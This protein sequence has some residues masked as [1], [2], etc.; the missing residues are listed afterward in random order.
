MVE[1]RQKGLIT[2]TTADHDCLQV[3]LAVCTSCHHAMI[4]DCSLEKIPHVSSLKDEQ[5]EAVAHLLCSKDVVGIL[6][7]GFGK[8]LIH[9][10]YATAKQMQI[11]GNVVVLVVFTLGISIMNDQ[12]EEMEEFEIPLNILSI[13]YDVLQSIGD[14]KYKLVFGAAENVSNAEV[15]DILKHEDCALYN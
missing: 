6:P 11:V 1:R 5:K 4:R 13:T 3:H 8:S 12:I 14:A 15:E 9:Q 10:L 7:T 2:L